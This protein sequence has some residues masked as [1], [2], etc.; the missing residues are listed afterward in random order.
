MKKTPVIGLAQHALPVRGC[1]LFALMFLF[2][3]V[4]LST[5]FAQTSDTF[6]L[7]F[8]LNVPELNAN[9]GKRIDLLILNN[10]IIDGNSI[11]IVGYA[12]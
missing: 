7:Y 2:F 6:R 10:K 8:D 1:G 4:S 12:D 11:E 3:I 9:T 5:S